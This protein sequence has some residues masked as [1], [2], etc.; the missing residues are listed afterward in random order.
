M[1][2]LTYVGFIAGGVLVVTGATLLGLS[3][4]K[5]AGRVA[6]HPVLDPQHAGLVVRGSF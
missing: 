4:R 1:N 3:V 2:A 6:V 5:Q